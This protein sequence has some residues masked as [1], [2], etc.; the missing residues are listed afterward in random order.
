MNAEHVELPR[1]V[2][3]AQVQVMLGGISRPTLRALVRD[4]VLR[5][6]VELTRKL[7]LWDLAEINQVM[8]QR[9][10]AAA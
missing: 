5:P 10:S 2:R 7:H 1:F 8:E 6:P 3:A 9:R 4:G